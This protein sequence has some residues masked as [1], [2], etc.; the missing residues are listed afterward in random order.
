MEIALGSAYELETQLIIIE[1][2]L[3]KKPTNTR[4]TKSTTNTSKAN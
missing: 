2:N 1:S 3:L 4:N